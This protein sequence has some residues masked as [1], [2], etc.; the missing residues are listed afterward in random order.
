MTPWFRNLKLF[1][2]FVAFTI[3]VM[4]LSYQAHAAI[5]VVSPALSPSQGEYSLGA[6][7]TDENST[8]QSALLVIMP[9]ASGHTSLASSKFVP[10]GVSQV[11]GRQQPPLYKLASGAKIPAVSLV[12][13]NSS[14]VLV[15]FA[16]PSSA[17]SKI[18]AITCAAGAGGA[19]TA[20]LTCTGLLT[21]DTILSVFQHT[22]GANSLP[23]LGY[24]TVVSNGLTAIW[25]AD[26][27]AGAVVVVSVLHQ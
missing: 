27:G 13:V 20:A 7:L 10:G 22:A 9:D 1:M 4:L 26:P 8:I 25:S 18:A 23:L 6:S 2:T 16:V 24:S 15:P 21:T 19:A 11:T 12:S 17:L 14:D 3:A 5:T